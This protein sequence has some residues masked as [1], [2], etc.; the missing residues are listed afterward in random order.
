MVITK[1][2]HFVCVVTLILYFTCSFTD[3]F[4]IMYNERAY[5]V[6]Y[7]VHLHQTNRQTV[8]SSIVLSKKYG[9]GA[10]DIFTKHSTC[11]VTI[12]QKSTLFSQIEQFFVCVLKKSQN[13]K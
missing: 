8:I 11:Y 12:P 3:F 6:L 5:I 4:P 9:F 13:L 10:L 2:T 7:G 1:N